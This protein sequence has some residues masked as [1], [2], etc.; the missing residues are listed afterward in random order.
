MRKTSKLILSCVL[1]GW[2][3]CS[4]AQTWNSAIEDGLPAPGTD[5]C[6][7]LDA[8][9]SGNSFIGGYFTG[10]VYFGAASTI[11]LTSTGTDAFL[12]RLISVTSG[13][14]W[15]VKISGTGSEA[16]RKVELAGSSVIVYGTTTASSVTLN[17]TSGSPVTLTGLSGA[18]LAKYTSAGVI[19]WAVP[20]AGN[21]SDMAFVPSSGRLYTI[22]ADASS[23]NKTRIRSV[24][25]TTGA[26]LYDVLSTNTGLSTVNKGIAGDA[27]NHCYILVD[28]RTDFKLPSSSTITLSGAYDMVL[29]KLDTNLTYQS[30]LKIGNSGTTD[31]MA[32]DVDCSGTGDIYITGS[33]ANGTAYMDGVGTGT[34]NL[35]N[36]GGTDLCLAKYTNSLTPVWAKS[37]SGA[38]GDIPLA[39]SLDPN[40]SNP[41]LLV[42]NQAT[43]SVM[44]DPCSSSLYTSATS[45]FDNKWYVIKYT[46]TGTI[47]WS[48]A[49]VAIDATALPVAVQGQNT[50]ANIFGYNLQ[51]TD[52][53]STS[54]VGSGSIYIARAS[55]LLGCKPAGTTGIEESELENTLSVYP[56]PTKGEFIIPV[57]GDDIN[58]SISMVDNMG[59]QVL[60]LNDV[61]TG[62]INIEH[63]ANGIY[64][65]TIHKN[66]NA[67]R[68]K[69]VKE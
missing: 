9:T 35:S 56:N 47:D 21:V 15:A 2:A 24:N 69:I 31:E 52:F 30:Y 17:G 23:P 20:Y 45:G 7:P 41:F 40:S 33:Y 36:G 12:T 10:T 64:F 53:G 60:N 48:A 6:R 32:K 54:L 16:I 51:Q 57:T 66:G 29:M 19:S 50:S 67:Y 38:G 59:K 65:Y 63:L 61:K 14:S 3:A 39:M 46:S 49:P 42:Q 8:T 28:G 27:S 43:N 22:G 13:A 44:V 4:Q 18:F 25:G 62:K 11:T 58:V 1:T 68:G 37:I 55:K 26:V 34:V 5:N